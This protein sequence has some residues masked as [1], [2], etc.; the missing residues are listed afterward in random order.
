MRYFRSRS[1]WANTLFV[2]VA[3]FSISYLPFFIPHAAAVTGVPK[4]ISYQGRLANASGD[5]LGGSGTSYY[6]K[7]SIWNSPT[8]SPVTGS[9]LW[10]SASSSVTTSTVTSGV[11]N[12]AIG[13]T[14]N[15]YPDAL[16]YD[17][18]E[19]RD[20]YLQVE[21]SSNGSSFETLSPRQRI[22]ASGFAISAETVTGKLYASSTSDYTFNVTNEGSGRANLATEGQVQIGAFTGAPTTLG[23]GS[24]YYNSSTGQLFLWDAATSTPAW[25]SL[26]GGGSGGSTDLQAAYNLGN[27]ITTTNARNILFTAADTAT[28]SNFVFNILGSTSTAVFEIQASS[29]P[30]F[31]VSRTSV[32]STA[33]LT[34]LATTTVTGTLTANI[35]T[36]SGATLTGGAINNTPIGASTPTSATFTSATTTGTFT[37][38]GV[39]SLATTTIPN[40]LTVQGTGTALSVTNSASVGD[41]L[42]VT[43]ALSAGS[44]NTAGTLTANIV[45]ATT[46]LRVNNVVRIDQAGQG[47]FATTSITSLQVSG[48]STFTGASTFGTLSASTLTL[49]NAL[50]IA[51]GGTATTTTPSNGQL[52]IGNGTNYSL[53]TLTPGTAI[54]IQNAAGSIT[55]TNLGVQSLTGGTGI[56]VNNATGTVSLTNT[57]PFVTSTVNGV[58]TVAFTFAT[59]TA[60]T[61]G[62]NIATSA[63]TLTWNFPGRINDINSIATSTGNLIVASG[64]TWV[65]KSVGSNGFVLTAS[66][67]AASG[68]SWEPAS[69]S[70][71]T[72]LNGSTSSTQTFSA[73]TGISIGT[74]NGVHTFTNIG[75]QSLTAGTNIT[76]TSATGTPTISVN[77]T[78]A[79]S[80][81]TNLT[82]TG[83][84]TVAFLNFTT[85]TG[86]TANIG[87]LTLTNALGIASGGTATTTTPSNGQLLI[88][89]GTN[90]SLATL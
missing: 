45:N 74:S 32:T 25:T 12:V 14:A 66:S 81:I 31:S 84:S 64:T 59:T 8:S 75:V 51:S 46:S 82:A 56:S 4:I 15:G 1:G 5:L 26:G 21:V 17:F 28:D 37:A 42:T 55:V 27:T 3:V 70:G 57:R 79:T 52:L 90:Y 29:S 48:T 19:N 38:Q 43:N 76:L 68:L 62:F 60:Y 88:G 53:A 23:G 13:D 80:T 2:C 10:P 18:Y 78:F 61:G 50:G 16:T 65:A 34:S 72:S 22:A 9:Q 35:F 44:L 7:F 54:G 89:N 58:E 39:V 71:I 83:S 86:T 77:S 24:L 47:T 63:N 87:T 41:T 40:T 73:G 69:A 11:F 85:A 33:A 67:T 30:V 6:F 49:T 20:V 36:S